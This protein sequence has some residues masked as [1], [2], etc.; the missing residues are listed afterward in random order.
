MGEKS[1][2]LQKMR[3]SSWKCTIPVQFIHISYYS[4]MV[5]NVTFMMQHFLMQ[6]I[7]FLKT[8]LIVFTFYCAFIDSLT[9]S[10]LSPQGEAS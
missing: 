3:S 9:Q 5:P 6:I 4:H 2:K 7:L 1:G 8:V 10:S